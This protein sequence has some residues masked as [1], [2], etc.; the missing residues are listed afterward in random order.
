MTIIYT[1]EVHQTQTRLGVCPKT[2][3]RQ[4]F[5]YFE[6]AKEWALGEV[7]GDYSDGKQSGLAWKTWFFY[8]ERTGK[9]AVVQEWEV[10]DDSS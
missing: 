8:S 6:N 1:V 5:R 3:A 2:D 7:E 10:D 4:L 9:E